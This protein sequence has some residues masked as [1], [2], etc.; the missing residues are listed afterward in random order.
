MTEKI[1]NRPCPKKGHFILSPILDRLRRILL[2]LQH[3]HARKARIK[4]FLHR[5]LGRRKRLPIAES[6]YFR[7]LKVIRQ[8]HALGGVHRKLCARLRYLLSRADHLPSRLIP[9]DM[10][11]MNTRFLLFNRSGK[12]FVLT[13][14]Y[15]E[16]ADKATGHISVISHLGMSLLGRRS[17][18]YISESLRVGAVVYQPESRNDFHL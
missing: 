1:L 7:L 2:L 3:W 18:E 16:D 13:L 9:A 8:E 5:V 14:V 15:P 4:R 6:D 12:R 11:T 17:G 10:I